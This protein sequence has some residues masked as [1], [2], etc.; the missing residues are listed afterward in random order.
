MPGG[1]KNPVTRWIILSSSLFWKLMLL[2][3]DKL[4][5]DPKQDAIAIWISFFLFSGRLWITSKWYARKLSTTWSY[6]NAA[7]SSLI[8]CPHNQL[9]SYQT[10]ITMT[11]WCETDQKARTTITCGFCRFLGVENRHWFSMFLQKDYSVISLKKLPFT[12]WL[13]LSWLQI[14]KADCISTSML[15]YV[16][17]SSI[18][19]PLKG[20]CA[21]MYVFRSPEATHEVVRA[22]YVH[23]Q[24][25]WTGPPP[26]STS[27]H[28]K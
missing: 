16:Q 26:T 15:P 3:H 14:Y 11:W 18:F 21:V 9:H 28:V 17:T 23:L 19:T 27:T 6:L 8:L 4:L 2:Y 7:F 13:G 24:K 22:A 1:E 20:Y 5:V 12:S 10:T 25:S